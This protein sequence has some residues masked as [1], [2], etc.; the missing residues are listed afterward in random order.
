MYAAHFAAGLAIKARVPDAPTWA[1]LTAAFIP[2]FAWIIL[3]RAGVE[4]TLP[5]LFFDD[6]SHSLVTIV[7][8][9]A[10]FAA[11]FW[12]LGRAVLAAVWLA[13]FSHFLLDLPIHPKQLALYPHSPVHLGFNSWA[14]GAQRPF[15]VTNYWWIQL[16]ALIGLMIIYVQGRRRLQLPMNLVV[17]SCVVLLSLHLLML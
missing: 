16:A 9:A 17:A 1:L 15:G 14:F 2:D 3:A 12:R 10:L 11:L 8:C 7:V 4:P 13:A 6:W 5:A